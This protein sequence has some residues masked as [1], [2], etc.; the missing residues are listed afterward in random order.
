MTTMRRVESKCAVC[1]HVFMHV[2]LMSTNSF[3]SPDLDLRPPGMKRDTM[4]L[5]IQECPKCGYISE[6]ISDP[7][8][9]TKEFLKS[10]E[11]KNC[12]GIKFASGLAEQFYKYHKINLA[13]NDTK[14]A[15]F[16]LLHA[17]WAC[18]D[19]PDDKNA[20]LCR[21]KALPLISLLI[22]EK[23]KDKETLKLMKA[24]ILRRAGRF[25]ELITEYKDV[26]FDQEVMDQILAFELKLA[27]NK[28]T[29]CYRVTDA[30]N[31]SQ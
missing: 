14:G 16:A 19:E 30:V 15:F 31:A 20:R 27:E 18:D 4:H 6:D 21:E 2:E 22:G 23:T 13:E 24:D 12:D 8:P 5:W 29:A 17:A 7:R 1:G 28:D 3:G 10:K 9:I 11:Y 26:R 25:Q